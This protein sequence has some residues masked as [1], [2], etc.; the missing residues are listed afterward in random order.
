MTWAPTGCGALEARS[1]NAKVVLEFL[2]DIRRRYPPEVQLYIVM[3]GLSAH[4]T[5]DIR[6]WAVATSS[7][8]CPPDQRQPPQ[9]HRVPLL[10][11]RRVRHQR[12]RLPRLDRVPKATQAYIRRRNRDRHD[13]DRNLRTTKVA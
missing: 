11:L 4:W 13:R 3:D 9:P 8:C 2:K 10:G 1:V 6:D 7:G 12:L 5:Q